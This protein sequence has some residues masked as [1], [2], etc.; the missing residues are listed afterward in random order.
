MADQANS[1]LRKKWGR[2]MDKHQDKSRPSAKQG[3]F[4]FGQSPQTAKEQKPAEG[5]GLLT[6]A[7][8]LAIFAQQG[9]SM[10]DTTE[11]TRQR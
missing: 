9:L 6:T 7:Q 11:S 1:F 8:V 2:A 3:Q 5:T 4:D 10:I